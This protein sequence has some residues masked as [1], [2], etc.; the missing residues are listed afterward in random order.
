ML[1]DYLFLFKTQVFYDNYFSIKSK[2][3]STL[4]F[5]DIPSSIK[6][7]EWG[8]IKIGLDSI[9][10]LSENHIA[11]IS[12]LAANLNKLPIEQISLFTNLKFL[13]IVYFD[14]E[15]RFKNSTI[16]LS[17]IFKLTNIEHLSIGPPNTSKSRIDITNISNDNL[18]ELSLYNVK[19]LQF[20]QSSFK[21]IN[22]LSFINC[23]LNE[24]LLDEISK[25]NNL[26]VLEI[27]S[28][29]SLNLDFINRINSLQALCLNGF[30]D[31]DNFPDLSES[32][33]KYLV[34]SGFKS[35]ESF[36]FI[37]KMK[38]L[39]YVHILT[40]SKKVNYQSFERIISLKN[41]KKAGLVIKGN[42]KVPKE[43]LSFEKYDRSR[44]KYNLDLEETDF[45]KNADYDC[46]H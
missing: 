31:L 27:V 44:Y 23:G 29:K 41:L 36:D 12:G 3:S 43:I 46:W 15:R 18:K 34:L 22:Y 45:T 5:N 37:E 30:V 32:N 6:T 9:I 2:G 17:E 19:D 1:N 16:D 4:D 40:K 28:K 7:I 21:A 35:L 39:E 11:S 25:L 13:R 20:N 38:N 26:Q 33:I 8:D 14:Q 10:N 24:E 42:H